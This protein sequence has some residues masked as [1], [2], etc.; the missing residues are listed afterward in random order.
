MSR[1]FGMKYS[2][3]IIL[4]KNLKINI[5]V[6]QFTLKALMMKNMKKIF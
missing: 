6:K 4:E 5:K 1:N 3:K 2:F